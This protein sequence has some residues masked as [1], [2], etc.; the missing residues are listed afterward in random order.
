MKKISKIGE[1]IG[2]VS[3]VVGLA[4]STVFGEGSLSKSLQEVYDEEMYGKAMYQRMVDEFNNDSYYQRL[5]QGEDNHAKSVSRLMENLGY[6][7]KDSSYDVKISQDELTALKD[8]LEYEIKDVKNL[9][10]RMENTEN[11][12]ELAL[13]TRLKDRSERHIKSLGNA[14]GALE[15]G[16]TDLN[17]LFCQGCYGQNGQGN[18]QKQN[19]NQG[20]NRQNNFCQTNG[21]ACPYTNQSVRR[22][23]GIG[24]SGWSENAINFAEKGKGMN[25]TRKGGNNQGIQG[26]LDCTGTG[27][28]L[29][30]LDGSGRN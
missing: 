30:K 22:L 1:F 12:V 17:Q 18:S 28:Q 19:G 3:L 6:E 2:A 20:Q 15:S 24:S 11:Q 23:D 10:S 5:V 27:N 13:Y 14:I 29:R 4:T 21:V 16:K 8:A 7:V 26:T 9:Q 25:S